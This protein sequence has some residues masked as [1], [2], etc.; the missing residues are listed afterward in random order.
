MVGEE[1]EEVEGKEV[2][3]ARSDGSGR[4]SHQPG[5]SDTH[6]RA[7]HPPQPHIAD[8]LPHSGGHARV[9]ACAECLQMRREVG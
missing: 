8:E 7:P 9:A 4:P 6:V 2:Q 5:A 3:G 1:R